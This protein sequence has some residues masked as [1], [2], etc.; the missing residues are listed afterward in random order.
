MNG[1]TNMGSWKRAWAPDGLRASE[2]EGLTTVPKVWSFAPTRAPST[3]ADPLPEANEK[4]PI[5]GTPL[6][7]VFDRVWAY[8]FSTLEN[9]LCLKRARRP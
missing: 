1:L 4:L 8:W 2:G 6:F 5:A 9:V 3:I 7:T